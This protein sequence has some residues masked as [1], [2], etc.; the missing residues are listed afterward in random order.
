MVTMCVQINEFI[1]R[2]SSEKYC[3]KVEVMTR[4]NRARRIA[5]RHIFPSA[6]ST[7]IY[8]FRSLYA[9]TFSSSFVS[10]FPNIEKHT[11]RK[12]LKLSPK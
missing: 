4:N 3:R 10:S 11:K 9:K 1:R 8:T 12:K 6:P 5:L 2:G 7:Y